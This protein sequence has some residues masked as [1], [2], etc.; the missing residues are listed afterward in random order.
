MIWAA[1]ED[2]R[3]I[4]TS[5]LAPSDAP[6]D[7]DAIARLPKYP[8][9]KR[10]F[11]HKQMPDKDLATSESLVGNRNFSRVPQLLATSSRPHRG[12]SLAPRSHDVH[13]IGG[14]TEEAQNV[15]P[16][17]PDFER[18]RAEVRAVA[19]AM[20]REGMPE[21]TKS[22]SMSETELARGQLDRD[23]RSASESV[24]RGTTAMPGSATTAIDG[25]VSRAK[26]QE[27]GTALPQSPMHWTSKFKFFNP[28][29]RVWPPTPSPQRA[30]P[31]G[32]EGRL[33]SV[34]SHAGAKAGEGMGKDGRESAAI[35]ISQPS[36]INV[37]AMNIS[38]NA[39]PS[40][41]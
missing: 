14:M 10:Y 16:R 30:P 26:E 13:M 1:A 19:A 27:N 8:E 4:S 6:P 35:S 18:A 34:E 24:V 31:T 33:I 41:R 15:N 17:F 36:P 5:F 40:I 20:G 28:G 37:A 21:D 12:L 11:A 2:V 32:R 23:R 39:Q 9:S 22:V 25:S 7:E 3:L 29:H 38:V